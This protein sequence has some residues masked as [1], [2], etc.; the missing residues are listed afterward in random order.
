M[1]QPENR[2]KWRETNEMRQADDDDEDLCQENIIKKI[3]YYVL[4]YIE[5][6]QN[7]TNIQ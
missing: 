6:N 7:S 2:T 3:H 5:L 4:L 1:R